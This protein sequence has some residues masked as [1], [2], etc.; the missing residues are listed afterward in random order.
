MHALMSRYISPLSLKCILSMM[1]VSAS[2]FFI[3]DRRE[4]S[5]DDCLTTEFKVFMVGRFDWVG[6]VDDFVIFLGVSL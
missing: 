6:I 4:W 2:I 5:V 1:V 3:D